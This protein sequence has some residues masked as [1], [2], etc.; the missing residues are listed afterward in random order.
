MIVK[1]TMRRAMFSGAGSR[2]WSTP[3][4]L[5][6]VAVCCA[7]LPV[8]SL[9]TTKA[10]EVGYLP[11]SNVSTTGAT[12]EVPINPEGGETSYEIS[13]ECQSA[14]QNNQDC[15]S[16]TAGSQRRQGVIAPGFEQSIVTDPITG[17]QPGYLY[18]YE[19]IASNSDGREG[20]VGDG[21]L[22]CSPQGLCAQPY[23]I[24]ESLWNIEGAEREAKEAP[25]LEEEREAKQKEEE[26]R[27]TKEA[28]AR[29]THEREVREAG[30]RAGRE[31][32]ERE[33]LAK[34]RS[35]KQA[36]AAMCRVPSLKGDS[37]TAARHALRKVHCDLGKVSEPRK[38][39][40]ALVVKTQSIRA[41]R[42]LAK[43]TAV[44]VQL[45]QA[46]G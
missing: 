16:L 1:L 37:L 11:A 3:L 34:E 13:L 5:L 36:A 40:G 19:V 2:R 31:A 4:V 32:A 39:H 17:L 24:G 46:R 8:V 9:A 18:K 20:Y 26:E 41:G 28:A 21:F 12:I 44:A 42:K 27:P 38:H 33:R 45:G 10:P 35:A 23:L 6:A 30:E 29:D 22:T 25:R 15:E 7:W 43:G 14:T